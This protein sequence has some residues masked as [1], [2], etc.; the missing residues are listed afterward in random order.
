M[1]YFYDDYSLE[2]DIV[3]IIFVLSQ[4]QLDIVSF[5]AL[6]HRLIVENFGNFENIHFS[7]AN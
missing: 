3:L 6:G 7:V 1:D 5:K 2:L 4:E